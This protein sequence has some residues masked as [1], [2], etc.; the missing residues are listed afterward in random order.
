M[1][2]SLKTSLTTVKFIPISRCPSRTAAK[3]LQHLSPPTPQ[4]F[5]IPPICHKFTEQRP[6][7][8]LMPFIRKSAAK[9]H[10]KKSTLSSVIWEG[11]QTFTH[12]E[13]KSLRKSSSEDYNMSGWSAKVY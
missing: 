4:P 9:A 8:P 3:N 6:T 5:T 13:E 7:L 12:S 11:R 1:L 10:R 2:A